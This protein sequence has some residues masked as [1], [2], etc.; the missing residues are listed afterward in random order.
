MLITKGNPGYS[1]IGDAGST[2]GWGKTC[3]ARTSVLPAPF[4][5]KISNLHP[6]PPLSRGWSAHLNNKGQI[7]ALCSRPASAFCDSVAFVSWF[8]PAP[9]LSLSLEGSVAGKG[10]RGGAFH[11]HLLLQRPQ[12]LARPFKLFQESPGRVPY[13]LTN[14]SGLLLPGICHFPV[15]MPSVLL[16]A[17]ALL[18]SWAG[19]RYFVDCPGAQRQATSRQALEFPQMPMASKP[20]AVNVPTRPRQAPGPL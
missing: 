3:W 7:R 4:G 15:W 1:L 6:S 11:R 20:Y 9:P 8:P 18:C 17:D 13:V 16:I 14:K 12:P 19:G 2:H 10:P 5:C